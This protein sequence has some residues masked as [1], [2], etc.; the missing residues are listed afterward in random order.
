MTKEEKKVTA[1]EERLIE[2]DLDSLR[3]EMHE[4]LVPI[5]NLLHRYTMVIR[6]GVGPHARNNR[7][8]YLSCFKDNGHIYFKTENIDKE[9]LGK[10]LVGQFIEKI[11][12]LSEEVEDL[13]QNIEV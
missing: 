5:N 13:K 7:V 10:K 1:L 9:I 2:K 11:E 8:P 6:E 3:E 4:L 12:S